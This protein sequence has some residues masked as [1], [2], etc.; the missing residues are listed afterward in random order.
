MSDIFDFFKQ[1]ESKLH[2]RP[3]EKVWKQLEKKLEK[4]RRPKRRG[5]QFL[6]LGVVALII[7][8][9]ILMAV[10]VWHFSRK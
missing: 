1:N 10:M 9:L 3:P 7:L 4:S 5:I 2:E 6:Q 8:L